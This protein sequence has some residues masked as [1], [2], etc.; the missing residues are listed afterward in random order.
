MPRVGCRT[1]TSRIS[2]LFTDTTT[3]DLEVP[4]N[5]RVSRHLALKTLARVTA[6]SLPQRKATLSTDFHSTA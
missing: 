6:S 3:Q 1:V 4:R 5:G 2:S